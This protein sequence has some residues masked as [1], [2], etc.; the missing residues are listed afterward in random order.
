MTTLNPQQFPERIRNALEIPVRERRLR[1]YIDREGATGEHWT[2]QVDHSTHDD[3]KEGVTSK[4]QT[5][6]VLSK[7]EFPNP[8]E[9]EQ[10]AYLMGHARGTY[11]TRVRHA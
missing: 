9:A 10:T 6:V 7:K 1:S 8:S 3:L 2:F 11:P 5:R 4:Q